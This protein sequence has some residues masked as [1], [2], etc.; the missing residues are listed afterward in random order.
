MTNR[1][2]THRHAKRRT[3][4]P[5]HRPGMIARTNLAFS[6]GKSMFM[7]T[8]LHSSAL[9]A[10]GINRR[11][12]CPLNSPSSG[13]YLCRQRLAGL[14]LDDVRGVPVRP[15]HVILAG[16]LL[17]FAVRSRGAPECGRKLSR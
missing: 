8:A 6:L 9:A 10:R 1:Q 15:V 12:A 5:A 11:L 7:L 17:V 3:S 2:P 13:R 16:P 4:T 14:F